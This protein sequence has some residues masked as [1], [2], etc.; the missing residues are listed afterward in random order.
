MSQGKASYVVKVNFFVQRW[1]LAIDKKTSLTYLNINNY[2]NL[3]KYPAN[4]TMSTHKIFLIS[5]NAKLYNLR[6]WSV[7]LK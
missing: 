7:S 5:I 4:K 3:K 1:A 6:S 2:D